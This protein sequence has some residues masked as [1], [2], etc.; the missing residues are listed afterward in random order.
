MAIWHIREVVSSGYSLY[1][2]VDLNYRV[3]IF[4]FHSFSTYCEALLGNDLLNMPQHTCCQQ[5]SRKSDFY[6]IRAETEW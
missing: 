5:Y 2:M 4:G 6:V 3:A 1:C